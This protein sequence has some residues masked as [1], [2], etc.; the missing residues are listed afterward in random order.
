MFRFTLSIFL[1]FIGMQANAGAWAREKGELFVAAGGNFLLSPGAQLPVHYDPTVYAEWGLTERITLG[2]D[3]HTANRG[4]IVSAFSFAR[5]PIGDISANDRFAVSL[6]YGVSVKRDQPIAAIMRGGMSWGR[7][8]TNGWLAIDASA[9]LGTID[10]T[11]RPKIDAT[12]GRNWTDKWTTTLQLQT[13][14]GWTDDYYAKLSPTA[15]YSV[16]PNIK[17]ALGAVQGLTGDRGAALKLETW[18]SF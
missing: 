4:Q 17:F 16:R 15:I 2:A 12:W 11:W 7:G 8:I 6:G 18:F 14:Q 5:I 3:I 10:T 1:T 13:G 9:T